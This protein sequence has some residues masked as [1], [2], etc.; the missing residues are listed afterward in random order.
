[1]R[2]S[3]ESS[4]LGSDHVVDIRK[5]QA[6]VRSVDWLIPEYLKNSSCMAIS[7]FLF[8]KFILSFIFSIV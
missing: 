3:A 1:M 6:L 8:L 2:Y 4:G 5:G 7:T